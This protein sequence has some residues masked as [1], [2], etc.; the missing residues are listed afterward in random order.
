MEKKVEKNKRRKGDG[1][2]RKEKV[3]DQK[4]YQQRQRRNKGTQKDAWIST[5]K[6]EGFERHTKAMQQ[7]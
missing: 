4:L 6:G 1:K 5:C 2:Q 3:K 7:Q